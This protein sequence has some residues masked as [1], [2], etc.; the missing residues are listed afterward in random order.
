MP[1]KASHHFN[2]FWLLYELFNPI[3]IEFKHFRKLKQLKTN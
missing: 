2:K 1:H 3:I